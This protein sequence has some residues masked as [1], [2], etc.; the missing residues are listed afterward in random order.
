MSK[1]YICRF[2]KWIKFKI[3]PQDIYES[4]RPM[5]WIFL[6]IGVLPLRISGRRGNYHL[7]TVFLGYLTAFIMLIMMIYCYLTSLPLERIFLSYFMNH[8]FSAVVD[9]LLITSSLFATMMV[10]F[11]NIR[12]SY[13]FVRIIE[14]LA[15]VDQMLKTIGGRMKH[16]STT[17]NII[18]RLMSGSTLFS[19]YV[20]GSYKMLNGQ[21][22][23]T[24]LTTWVAYFL[25]HLLLMLVLFQHRTVMHLL[26]NRFAETSRVS[27]WWG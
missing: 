2:A 10:Y 17:V 4:L 26:V 25:P 7:Q 12:R 13:G 23:Q 19:I 8:S 9:R 27:F 5:I 15:D 1:L 22:M 16:G 20:I 14:R 3:F 24:H 6:M 21:E 11:K 18:M